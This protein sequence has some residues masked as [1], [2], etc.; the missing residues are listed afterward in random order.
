MARCRL[1]LDMRAA[2][3]PRAEL[4]TLIV[5]LQERD[6]LRRTDVERR[7]STPFPFPGVV[8]A[9]VEKAPLQRRK[10]APAAYH[11]SP[12]VVSL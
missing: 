11:R 5:I 6:E 3:S 4:A 10:E 2:R 9:L 1:G 8:L 12:C 7:V